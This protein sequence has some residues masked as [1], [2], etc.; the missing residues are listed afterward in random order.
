MLSKV[1]PS[2]PAQNE[3]LLFAPDRVTPH[4]TLPSP[5]LTL[6]SDFLGTFSPFLSQN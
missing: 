4:L 2:E 1:I 3:D 5:Y 6:P